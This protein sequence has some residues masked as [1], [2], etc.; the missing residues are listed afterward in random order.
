M[1][2]TSGKCLRTVAN[3]R[4]TVCVNRSGLLLPFISDPFCTGFCYSAPTSLGRLRHRLVLRC[5]YSRSYPPV[6]KT[7]KLEYAPWAPFVFQACTR[8]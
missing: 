8:Q 5:L 7:N 1:L 4:Y 2:T 6:R 3:H